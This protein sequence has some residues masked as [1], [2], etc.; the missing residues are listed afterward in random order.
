[1]HFV[2]DRGLGIVVADDLRVGHFAGVV[3]HEPAAD[4]HRPPR[5]GVVAEQPAGD[6]DLVDALVARLAVA[7]VPGEAA[8]VLELVAIDR[9]L[10]GRPAPQI[11]VE[12]RGDRQRLGAFADRVARLVGERGRVLD[13]AEVPGFEPAG[14]LGVAADGAA[15]RADLHE[16]V[17]FPRGADHLPALPDEVRE[18][19]LAIDLAAGLAGPDRRQG[20]P[21]LH[22]GHRHR[23][24]VFAVHEPADV[25][26]RVGPV[27]EFL[28]DQLDERGGP[29]AVGIAH[30]RDPHALL[31]AEPLHVGTAAAAAADHGHADLFVGPDPARGGRAGRGNRRGRRRGAV[32]E[33]TTRHGTGHGKTPARVEG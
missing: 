27:A 1:M 22:R 13:L 4:A 2:Q 20:V 32:N 23:V 25:G 12:R 8:I 24:E 15:L 16:A 29:G 30:G 10:A 33:L 17:V 28:L 6:V 9:L 31:R 7:H 18:R 11:V 3:E 19:L 21:I 5:Q 14:H 26:D